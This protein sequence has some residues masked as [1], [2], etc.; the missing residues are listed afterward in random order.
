M[1][2]NCALEGRDVLGACW[3]CPVDFEFIIC[4]LDVRVAAYRCRYFDFDLYIPCVR[5][6]KAPY[7]ELRTLLSHISYLVRAVG[8][9]EIHS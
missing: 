3:G 5:L 6:L 1:E 8:N 2:R 9:V 4:E 7:G